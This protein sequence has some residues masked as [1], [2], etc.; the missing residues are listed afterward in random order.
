MPGSQ[1]FVLVFSKLVCVSVICLVSYYSLCLSF[2]FYSL[3]L[4]AFRYLSLSFL[5]SLAKTESDLLSSLSQLT[6]SYSFYPERSPSLVTST[7]LDTNIFLPPRAG[8]TSLLLSFR[9]L[10]AECWGWRFTVHFS[11]W[12]NLYRATEAV[13]VLAAS[14]Q[15]KGTF[16]DEIIIFV[17]V[18]YEIF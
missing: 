3:T 6:P 1:C 18:F 2:S 5:S 16:F 13:P 10:F 11:C 17:L 15:N 12:L 9:V 7:H 8:A 4:F 14:K